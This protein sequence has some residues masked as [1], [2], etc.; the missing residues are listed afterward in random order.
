MVAF[1]TAVLLCL[2]ASFSV[3]SASPLRP[4]A[5]QNATAVVA[6]AT[7]L[8]ARVLPVAHAA[9]FAVEYVAQDTATGHEVLEYEATADAAATITL[10]GSSAVAVASA[11]NWYLKN[12]V[13]VFAARS[14]SA[15][16]PFEADALPNL[17]LPLPKAKRRMVRPVRFSWYANVC[18]ASYSHVWW[19]WTRWEQE[20]DLMAL[21]GVNIMYAH[22]GTEYVQ[23]KVWTALLGPNAT[24]GIA[25]YFVGP[26]FLAWFRMGNI[27]KWGGPMPATF[28]A[29]QHQLQLQILPRL[30]SLGIIGVLPAFAGFVPDA[31]RYAYPNASIR[32][33]SLWMQ[34]SEYSGVDVLAATDPLFSRIGAMFIE[35]YR[36]AYSSSAYSLQHFYSADSFNE[37]S[38][39][40]GNASYLHDYAAA[41]HRAMTSVDVEAVWVLQAWAF[42]SNGWT[43][44]SV[45][46]YLSGVSN[47]SMLLLDLVSDQMPLWDG[48]WASLHSLLPGQC[49]TDEAG[50]AVNASCVNCPGKCCDPA[51]T[52]GPWMALAATHTYQ[53]YYGKAWVFCSLNNYGGG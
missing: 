10:R 13:R 20:I 6:A 17:P 53:N 30:H 42:G 37:N 33:G 18:T 16:P 21:Q 44:A 39:A 45:G 9:A 51:T 50:W 11:L 15:L 14:W 25:D 52:Q 34:S 2:I 8:L 46:A 19:N 41:T 3:S 27:K 40:S 36:S 35:G 1:R 24:R 47:S 23:A 28:L 38:P 48:A 29:K 26:A 12:E 22:T 31:L 32:T 43:D 5:P 49:C 7:A 4:A